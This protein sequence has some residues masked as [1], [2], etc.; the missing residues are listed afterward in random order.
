[1]QLKKG[2]AER[3][4]RVRD[5]VPISV[6]AAGSFFYCLRIVML[7]CAGAV[8][9]TASCLSIYVQYELD[10]GFIFNACSRKSLALV[11]LFRHWIV[12]VAGQ[13]YPA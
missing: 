13:G 6:D 5:I 4:K 11:Q 3:K 8:F 1:M 2:H 12:F 7:K 9:T 10:F